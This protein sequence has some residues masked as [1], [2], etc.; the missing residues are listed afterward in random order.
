MQAGTKIHDGRISVLAL[1]FDELNSSL[2][3]YDH[4]AESRERHGFIYGDMKET[5]I[6]LYF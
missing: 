4:L 6:T 1:Y 2:C 3:L 5:R